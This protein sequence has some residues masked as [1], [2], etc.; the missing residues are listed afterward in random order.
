MAPSVLATLCSP[1]RPGLQNKLLSKLTRTIDMYN[2]SEGKKNSYLKKTVDL[3][4]VS[5]PINLRIC[6]KKVL[7]LTVFPYIETSTNE[8]IP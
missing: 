7:C 8:A 2:S 4:H 3:I 1:F 6:A 5:F